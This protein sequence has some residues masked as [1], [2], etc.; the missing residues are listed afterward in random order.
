MVLLFFIPSSL[1]HLG[2]LPYTPRL[3]VKAEM[4]GFVKK[5]KG[6]GSMP[7]PLFLP[8]DPGDLF[9]GAVESF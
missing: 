3:A 6:S 2:F 4:G 7:P 1:H 9:V 5:T 8:E